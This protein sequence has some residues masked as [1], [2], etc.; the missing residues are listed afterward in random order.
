[1]GAELDVHASPLRLLAGLHYLVLSGRASWGEVDEAL[2]RERAFLR[3]YVSRQ[4]VQTNE[5][6][7]TW[8]LLPC[9]LEV[10]RRSGAGVFD[11]LELGTSAGLNLDWDAFRF[12]YKAGSWGPA[13][14]VLSLEGEERGVVPP[15][16]LGLT[17]TV[18]FRVGIDRDP[19][20]AT[21]DEGA[22]LLASFVW[23]DQAWRRELLERAVTTL[24]TR[25]PVL[26]TGD[27]VEELPRLLAARRDGALTVVWQT[28]VLG[29]L[30]AEDQAQVRAQLD[31]EGSRA[32]L[33]FVEAT[34][35][36]DGA[37][38]YWGL[39]VQV[40]PGGERVEVAHGDFHGAWLDW[41]S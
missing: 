7:R 26:V 25:P 6:Q 24:R 4:S 37:E 34:R 22:R 20:D 30:S 12:A 19:I 3:E 36:L 2:D 8:M 39:S 27:I 31:E 18:R 38:T 11:L 9:F 1:M 41:H 15:E 10:A 29:Y 40:W 23:P 21:T 5:V 28:A 14:A 16:L 33:A 35:P 17:P 13:D 32:P